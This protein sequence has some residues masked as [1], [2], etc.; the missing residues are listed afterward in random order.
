MGKHVDAL[1]WSKFP[2]EPAAE[3]AKWVKL[4]DVQRALTLDE[5]Q[6]TWSRL[7]KLFLPGAGGQVS[8]REMQEDGPRNP[9][10]VE[11]HVWSLELKVTWDGEGQTAEEAIR[12]ALDAPARYEIARCRR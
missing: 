10:R 3:G 12:D 6:S 7:E 4:E 8:I 11:A 5:A 1:N 2:N 9:R